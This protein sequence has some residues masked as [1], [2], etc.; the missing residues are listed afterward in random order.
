MVIVNLLATGEID[1]WKDW[2]EN[3]N[4]KKKKKNEITH[5]GKV[6]NIT[7]C[8]HAIERMAGKAFIFYVGI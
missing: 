3:N 4:S 2:E 5:I 7:E 6:T 1:T 8:L